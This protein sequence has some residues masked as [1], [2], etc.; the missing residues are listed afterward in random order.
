MLNTFLS[1]VWDVNRE[2]LKIGSIEVRWY[3]LSWALCFIIGM[4]MF[5]RFFRK[6]GYPRKLSD[7]IFLFGIIS[8]IIGA[9]LGHC[10]FYEP[11]EYLANPWEILYIWHGGLASHGAAIG[12]LIGLWL[13]SRKSHIPYIWSLDRI[14][15][16]VTIGGGI[17]RLGNLMNSEIYGRPT[18]L[19]WGF[20][21]IRDPQWHQPIA[22]GGSGELP[23][24][25][26]QIYEALCY[27]ITFAI[28]VWLYYRKDMG[29]KRPGLLFGIGLVGVFLSRFL[30]EYIKNPQ[31]EFENNMSLFMGQ[32]LSIPFILAGIFFIVKACVKPAV[33][34]PAKSNP[35]YT[36]KAK[37]P[38]KKSVA[39]GAIPLKK[40]DNSSPKNRQN[41]NLHK[42][43]KK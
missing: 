12:L 18:S 21:F 4:I 3:G 23:V 38:T 34:I 22:A 10:L 33:P 27:F 43:V 36:D 24:H 11:A 14:M 15:I 8:T 29:R 19:P 35:V 25:P 41:N 42:K 13:F 7:S 20:E 1:V 40:E 31:V 9:R 17:V 39:P 32:W 37:T 5:D 6:E 26:T 30:I 2:I 16:P 28:L